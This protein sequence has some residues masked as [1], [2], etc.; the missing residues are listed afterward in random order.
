MKEP[1]SRAKSELR[2]ATSAIGRMKAAR[3]FP[4]FEDA[5]R[6]FL[7]SLEKVWKKAERETD[8]VRAQFAPWRKPAEDERRQD[9]L[10]RYVFHARNVD[11]HTIQEIVQHVP[12]STAVG[13]TSMPGG[14]WHIESM[15]LQDGQLVE[16]RG[17]TPIR[18]DITPTRIK[19]LEVK[20][21]GVSYPPPDRHLGQPLP[22]PD[23]V[24]VAE[25]ALSYYSRF[26]ANV[27]RT[28]F[29]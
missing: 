17:N 3:T 11:H 20:D 16:Y 13:P 29:R 5:W 9:P 1:L 2:A 19:L 6:D 25:L 22:A 14:V 26:V 7:S 21:R 12:G 8:V 18:V 24:T 27:E 10:L 4:E 15:T 28:F 23:P